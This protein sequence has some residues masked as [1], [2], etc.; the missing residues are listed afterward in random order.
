[1]LSLARQFAR[2]L[3]MRGFHVRRIANISWLPTL[4]G[5]LAYRQG[6]RVL[7]FGQT[8]MS[9]RGQIRV[10]PDSRLAI[11]EPWFFARSEPGSLIV[12][13]RAQLLV[14]G[15]EFAIKSGAFVELKDGAVLE[16]QG[17]NGYASRNL[18][19]ECRERITIG[20]GA[21]IGPDVI[22]RDND[23][24]PLTTEDHAAVRP[25]VIGRKV[26][27]GG[28]SI[29]LKGVTIGEGSIIAAGSVVTHDIPPNC[30]AAGA[31]A[32]VV[33]QGVSWK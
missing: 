6:L 11:N 4:W 1:M 32:K 5:T 17:G 19:I 24:H 33:R 14:T 15:G 3:H 9:I 31:P 18:Q 22:I 13:R 27:I 2:H 10:D 26:W 21:A 30:I 16:L 8:K 23:G 20:P 28:R 29:I 25:V 7:V 12:L